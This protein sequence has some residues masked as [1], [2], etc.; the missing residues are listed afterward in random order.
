MGS[1]LA[2]PA[3]AT[4]T[5]P[6]AAGVAAGSAQLSAQPSFTTA[7]LAQAAA[8]A[9][10]SSAAAQLDAAAWVQHFQQAQQVRLGRTGR[11]HVLPAFWVTASVRRTLLSSSHSC[12]PPLLL[13]RASPTCRSCSTSTAAT[14]ARHQVGRGSFAVLVLRHGAAAP[15]LHCL[16]A[17]PAQHSP[18]CGCASDA[19]P[20]LARHACR[21][22][23]PDLWRQPGS[24]SCCR[25]RPAVPRQLL[26]QPARRGAQRRGTAGRGDLDPGA[27]PAM[28]CCLLFW[29]GTLQQRRPDG[30]GCCWRSTWSTWLRIACAAVASAA[31]ARSAVACPPVT[32]AGAA[33]GCHLAPAGGS[34]V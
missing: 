26:L 6:M 19:A 15:A 5:R 12:F 24:Q 8:E 21:R 30:W 18:H 31:A 14:S 11:S 9:G 23:L 33:A 22:G 16:A 29:W 32:C 2:A 4:A 20:P 13:C 3:A 1:G 27:A 17:R 25:G 7:L 34:R 28:G 10:A